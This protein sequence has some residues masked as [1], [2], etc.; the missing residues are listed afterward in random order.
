M[1]DSTI[2]LR[3]FIAGE[4]RSSKNSQRLVPGKKGKARMIQS[5]AAEAYVNFTAHQWKGNAKAFRA[6]AK[7][8]PRPLT[9]GF[10]WVR[11]TKQTYDQTGPLEMVLDCMTGKKFKAIDKAMPGFAKSASWIDDDTREEICPLLY[12]HHIH[13]PQNPGVHIFLYADHP[14]ETPQV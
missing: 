10:L 12:K 1:P 13:D 3:I 4:V 6:A 7:D 2:L 11:G 8:L 9:V 14:I 5:E